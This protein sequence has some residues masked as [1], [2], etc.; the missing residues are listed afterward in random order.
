[1]R[2]PRRSNLNSLWIARKKVGLVQT[3]V[4]V[5]ARANQ[6]LPNYL[7][8]Y[9]KRCGLSQEEVAFLVKLSGKSELS[10]LERFH[11]QPS[12][13]TAVACSKV[14]GV[15]TSQL[16]RGTEV[17]VGRETT[18][19]MGALKKRLAANAGTAG[20]LHCHITR[21]LQ[22]LGQRLGELIPNFSLS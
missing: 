17:S 13:R 2:R 7:R 15:S 22:W 18:R 3:S 8:A 5:P 6:P 20:Y 11:R 14:F 1:M 9:R 21:K 12:Y 4:V 19:R 16:F 10:E